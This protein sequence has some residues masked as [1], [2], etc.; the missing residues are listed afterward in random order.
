MNALVATANSVLSDTRG[1]VALLVLGSVFLGIVFAFWNGLGEFWFR[2]GQQQELSHSYFLPLIAAW[3]LWERRHALRNSVGSPAISGLV[4]AA[5][6]L[7]LLFLGELTHIMV[8]EHVGF[9]ALLIALPLIFGGWSLF[10]VALI[11]LVYLFFMVPPPYWVITRLSHGFQLMSSELGVSMIRGFGI[12]VY[13][14]GNVIHLSSTKLQVVEACSGLRYLFPFLSL[15]ALAGYFY[16]GPIWQRVIIFLST[17]PITIVMNSLRIAATGVLVERYGSGH[18]EGFLHFFEGWVVFLLC[19]AFL[20]LVIWAFTL[21]RGRRSPF[22]YVGFEEV[23]PRTPTGQW[24]QGAFLRNGIILTVMLLVAGIL[25]HAVGNRSLITPERQDLATLPF[26]FPGYMTRESTLDAETATVLGADD[27]IISDMTSP[28][29]DYVNLYIAYL[30]AQRDGRSWHSPMQ[31]LPGGGWEVV[32][33]DIVPT[34]RANGEEYFHN[35]MLIQQ[36]D[37]RLLVYYWY[38]QRGRKMANEFVMKLSVMWDSL[39]KR[40]SDGAMVRLMTPVAPEETLDVAEARLEDM[41]R[42][43]EPKLAAYVPN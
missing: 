22:A 21:M 1:R 33:H 43:L 6:S 9:V 34:S 38:D 40:R 30:N 32:S 37:D 5:G 10:A 23:P 17:I 28:D 35:R 15:G 2:W 20:I 25:V 16:K 24:T 12:P 36:N 11:P 7:F 26:E 4:I 19:I 14:S 27:Y 42:S 8:L 29:G 13:L 39:I 31:C 18:T 3:M 41:R